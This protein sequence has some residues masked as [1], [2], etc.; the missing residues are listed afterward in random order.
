M[1]FVATLVK[2]DLEGKYEADKHE[3]EYDIGKESSAYF[4]ILRTFTERGWSLNLIFV[5]RNG[6]GEEY[7]ELKEEVEAIQAFS[8]SYVLLLRYMNRV[9]FIGF[10][11][12]VNPHLSIVHSNHIKH[13]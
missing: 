5:I 8:T 7:Q 6:R 10:D 3:C 11:P 13:C 12:V 9:F 1:R 2:I 4:R